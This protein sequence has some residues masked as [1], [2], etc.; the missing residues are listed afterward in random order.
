MPGGLTMAHVY[1][2]AIAAGLAIGS[3]LVLSIVA[4]MLAATPTS[5]GKKSRKS[6]L[7]S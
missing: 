1:L 6:D 2:M 7:Q 3:A 4:A 5:D